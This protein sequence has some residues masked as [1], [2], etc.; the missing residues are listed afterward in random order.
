MG[1]PPLDLSSRRFRVDLGESPRLRRG[2]TALDF[3]SW[4]D[5]SDLVGL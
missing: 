2:L 4:T 5:G 3:S 1:I